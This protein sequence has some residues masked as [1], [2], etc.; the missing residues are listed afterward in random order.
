M[1]ALWMGGF[2]P[3]QAYLP[4]LCAYVLVTAVPAA[5]AYANPT[6]AGRPGC[7]VGRVGAGP[8]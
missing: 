7:Q 1:T 8:A 2:V 6:P 3:D 5:R 4:F